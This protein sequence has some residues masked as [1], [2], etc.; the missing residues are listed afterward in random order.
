M[1]NTAWHDMV[2]P[3]RA[4]GDNNASG[5][6]VQTV[7]LEDLGDSTRLCVRT[8]FELVAV[9]DAMVKLGMETG[10]SESLEKLDTLT[11]T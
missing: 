7:T 3:H 8:R 11:A 2:R 1:P 6:M 5:I 4:P 10:W 9:R